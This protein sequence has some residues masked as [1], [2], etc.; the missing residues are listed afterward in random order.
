MGK[1]FCY[2]MFIPQQEIEAVQEQ[3]MGVYIYS[4]WGIAIITSPSHSRPV[5]LYYFT[6][7]FS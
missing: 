5:E 2:Q 7:E 4:I 3:K 6:A 1:F